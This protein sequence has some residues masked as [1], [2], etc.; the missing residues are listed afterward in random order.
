MV[1]GFVRDL[2]VDI[3]TIH[4][5]IIVKT[6]CRLITTGY[7]AGLVLMI[8]MKKRL[9]L[10]IALV[11]YF[12][13]AYWPITIRIESSCSEPQ[14]LIRM[15]F[16]DKR[17]L[18][19]F[20]RD[21]CFVN[22]WA[23]TM[24]GSKPMSTFQYTEPFA[25]VKKAFKHP[26][27]K[28]FILDAFWPPNIREICWLF[29]PEQLK[30]KRGWEILNK[31]YKLYFPQSNLALFAS[32]G[33]ETTGLLIVN[34]NNLIKVVSEHLSDFEDVL[35][36]QGITPE[37]LSNN[38]NLDIFLKGLNEEDECIRG[39]ILGFGRNNAWLYDQYSKMTV[40]EFPLVPMWP[41]EYEE[42]IESINKKEASFESWNFSDLFYPYFVCDPD[43]EETKKLKLTYL[44]DREKIIQHYSGKDVVEATLSLFNQ[45]MCR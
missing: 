43:S 14:I 28:D 10:I 7:A 8:K 23:Y 17:R 32:H 13:T 39:T 4:G 35:Q 25:Q 9:F 27:L 31:Y 15:P 37:Q 34:K 22:A 44:E 21:A 18:E 30:V 16:K 3:T 20:F 29:N 36:S 40:Q 38:E 12:S 1:V 26:R 2:G 45:K 42:W 6:N 5:T 19:Y 41:D 24:M 11:F 33:K